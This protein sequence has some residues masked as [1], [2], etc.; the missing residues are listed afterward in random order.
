MR[1]HDRFKPGEIASVEKVERCTIIKLG[2]VSKG[3]EGLEFFKQVCLHTVV[4]PT[5]LRVHY[6][7]ITS[8]LRI[9][10]RVVWDGDN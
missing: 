7:A 9:Y 2:L 1:F 6:A 8:C 10:I 5:S 3:G 4:T